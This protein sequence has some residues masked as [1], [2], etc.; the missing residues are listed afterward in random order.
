MR[1]LAL[2]RPSARAWHV[3]AAAVAC[4]LALQVAIVAGTFVNHRWTL[5]EDTDSLL[6][7][8]GG[9]L[10]DVGLVLSGNLVW[11]LAMTLL[12]WPIARLWSWGLD[13]TW[14]PVWINR[15]AR[16]LYPAVAV[17]LVGALWWAFS[18]QA[19][20]LSEQL[21]GRRALF[22]MFGHGT[23]ELTGLLLPLC[24]GFS[25]IR[26]PAAHPGR[27][28]LAAVALAMPLLVCGAL[29]EVYL[30]PQLLAFLSNA[31]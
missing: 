15:V 19:L 20:A 9:S 29:V 6:M 24:A 28:V 22:G 16:G 21:R 31:H 1:A 13:E 11:L 30:S 2:Q 4:S 8:R 5:Q 12:A 23:L 17:L 10:A 27:R 26:A 25:C 3:L 14:D 7:V 18:A